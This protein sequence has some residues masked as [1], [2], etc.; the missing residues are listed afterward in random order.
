MALHDLNAD[1]EH[2]DEKLGLLKER[3]QTGE[4]LRELIKEPLEVIEKRIVD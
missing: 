4:I 2:S 1:I 3:K